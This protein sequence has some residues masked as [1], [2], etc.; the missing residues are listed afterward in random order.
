MPSTLQTAIVGDGQMGL[1]L[2]DALAER[3]MKVRLWGRSE[4]RVRELAQT[5]RSP[6][7]LEG[8]VLADAVEVIADDAAL[9]DGVDLVVNAIPTQHIRSIWK[10]LAP[11]VPPTIP[12]VSVSKGIENDTL[13]RPTQV[14]A[15]ALGE[16]PDDP[17]R[18]MCALFGPTIATE[19]AN[20]QP[21]TLIAA[22]NDQSLAQLVQ[23]SFKVDWL[24][25]YRHDDL[26]GVE[27]AGATKNVIALAAGMIDGMGIGYNAKSALLSRGL[28]EIARL[29]AAMGARVDTFFGIAGVGD[30]ATTCFCPQGRN[31]SCG[32]RLGR[33]ESLDSILDSSV[34]VV[35]GVPTTRSVVQLAALHNVEMPI[36]TAVHAILFEGLTPADAISSLMRRE[37]KAEWIG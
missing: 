36:T 15:D 10:R 23:D 21:A 8:F 16:D 28:A 31:R 33:G 12:V 37:P 25:V 29:G 20:R 6:Q 11:H 14:V 2:A 22:A 9:L 30:L 27:L 1:V 32:E 13:L 4:E 17:A 7:R 34:F 35:E 3:G 5:R 19:L 26:L 18:A 24:R